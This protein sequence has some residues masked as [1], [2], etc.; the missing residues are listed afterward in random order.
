MNSPSQ[1]LGQGERRLLNQ[2]GF[3]LIVA[4]AL[5]GGLAGIGGAMDTSAELLA[6]TGQLQVGRTSYHWVDE[7]RPEPNTEARGA[8]RELTVYIW[9]P[10]RKK[11]TEEKPAPYIPEIQALEV[12]IGKAALKREAGA[13][14]DALFSARA[15]A[16]ADADL[17]PDLRKYP[18]LLF[19]H[20]LG[21]NALTYSMLAEELAS[22]GYIVV[23][24]N[25]PY[26]AF[27]VISSD[28][29]IIPFAESKW[30]M[31]GTTSEESL[32]R[33]R[34]NNDLC[35]VDM[36]FVLDQLERL[37][38]GAV[39]SRFKGRMELAGVGVFGHSIGGR[40]A[41][42][43]CQLEKRVKAC[44]SLDGLARRRHFDEN[45]DGS[46]LQQPFMIIRQPYKLPPDE[47]LVRMKKTRDQLIEENRHVR[48]DFFESVKAGS[49]DVSVKTPGIN[50]QS[51]TDLPLLES[52]Q[53]EE[54]IKACRR[55]MEI[56][57][58]YLRSFFDHHMLGRAA[59]LLE[60]GAA[61]PPEVEMTR[62]QFRAR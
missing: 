13:A 6:P 23:G 53:S 10:A 31:R 46:T 38:S 52:G 57:R 22:W 62:Y 11:G 30:N 12:A 28:N 4:L 51:F 8:K 39:L 42:R 32:A 25:H 21:G 14:Y 24:I 56:T 37:N 29:K 59:P 58:T 45:P 16:L 54:T 3:M 60:A 9:Y 49:Y 15:H 55:A 20:Q 19:S 7:S 33:E 50:H 5:G 44:L 43:T 41:A 2:P 18:V 17:N 1:H 27:A 34:K 48:Q 40:V 47:V 36:K 61:Q 26:V 35:A